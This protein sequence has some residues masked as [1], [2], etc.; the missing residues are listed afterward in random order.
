MISS[1]RMNGHICGY[2]HTAQQ[3]PCPGSPRAGKS[4]YLPRCPVSVRPYGASHLVHGPARAARQPARHAEGYAACA[5]DAR[6]WPRAGPHEAGRHWV[7]HAPTPDDA[8]GRG[9]S[10]RPGAPRRRAAH[11]PGTAF[12]IYSPYDKS[13]P[14]SNAQRVSREVVGSELYE[15][16]AD[17]H[18]IW[19]G[20]HAAHVWHRRRAF[21]QAHLA[22]TL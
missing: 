15:T 5:D 16:P 20:P 22:G 3:I 6:L 9:V 19:I 10:Q 21:L 8:L 1:I 11:D 4:A 12:T 7:L 17:T 14:P 2:H 13:V 18:L